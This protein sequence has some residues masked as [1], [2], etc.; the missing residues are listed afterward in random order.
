[1][2]EMSNDAK[3]CPWCQRWCLKDAAC[4]YVFA[5]GLETTGK[6]VVGAGCGRTW[7]WQ[8]GKKYCCPYY[9]PATGQRLPMAKD[10]HDPFC[11]KK[12]EGFKEESYCPG[13]HSSHCGRRW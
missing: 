10:H 13:G 11:C 2:V 1:M 6:F 7:C 9:N 8:C 4:D 5:C 12:E 3:Q